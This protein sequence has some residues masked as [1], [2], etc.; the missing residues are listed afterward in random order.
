[1]RALHGVMHCSFRAFHTPYSSLYYQHESEISHL[2]SYCFLTSMRL[3]TQAWLILVLCMLG[4]P[5][6][7]WL[8]SI[9]TLPAQPHYLPQLTR[10]KTEATKPKTE[11]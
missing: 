6:A 11:I 10:P 1:M 5:C 8:S 3:S 9:D 4:F 2:W 7:V